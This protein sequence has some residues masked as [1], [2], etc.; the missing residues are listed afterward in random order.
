MKTREET[1]PRCKS[2]QGGKK[3]QKKRRDIEKTR[4]KIE[5]DRK[6]GTCPVKRTATRKAEDF[7]QVP[8]NNIFKIGKKGNQQVKKK[9]KSLA[10]EKKKEVEKRNSKKKTDRQQTE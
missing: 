10:P 2:P 8:E 7:A 1:G 5:Q 4:K 3:P 6:A 9:R